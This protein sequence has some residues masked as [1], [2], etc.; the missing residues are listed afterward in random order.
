M[1]ECGCGGTQEQKDAK[2]FMSLAS[3]L[4][5]IRGTIIKADGSRVDIADILGVEKT[6]VDSQLAK[7]QDT[8]PYIRDLVIMEDG[9][10]CTLLDLIQALLDKIVD[11]GV[12][13]SDELRLTYVALSPEDWGDVSAR[14]FRSWR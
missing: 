12:V 7:A 10:T 5:L 8:F 4:P 6:P 1:F 14:S 13:Y 3:L 9:Q 2:R 11:A